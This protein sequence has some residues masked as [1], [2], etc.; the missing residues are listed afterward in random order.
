MT[1]GHIVAT[2]RITKRRGLLQGLNNSVGAD[3]ESDEVSEDLH[4][5]G[6]E[7]FK[8]MQRSFKVPQQCLTL[9]VMTG[10]PITALQPIVAF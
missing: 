9:L 2:T 4:K 8:T 1:L 3:S 5:N 10:R 6:V 7:M